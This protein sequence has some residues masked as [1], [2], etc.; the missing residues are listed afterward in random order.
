MVIMP[1]LFWFLDIYGALAALACLS[2]FFS[3]LSTYEVEKDDFGRWALNFCLPARW[4]HR[5]FPTTLFLALMVNIVALGWHEVKSYAVGAHIL[6][7]SEDSMGYYMCFYEALSGLAL[8]PQLWMFYH[9]KIV[10]PLLANFV[11]FFG[12]HKLLVFIFWFIFPYVTDFN[13]IN[14]N[15]QLGFD[16]IS[17]LIVTDFMYYW[18]RAKYHGQR[19][20]VVDTE[21]IPLTD[22]KSFKGPDC[23]LG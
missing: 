4:A 20:V 16:G 17:L 9:D 2:Y 21:E 3:H 23:A 22:V 12:V 18:F 5:W 13:P 8:V 15:I 10:A 14:R 11:F 7:F 6:V 1:E 19:D